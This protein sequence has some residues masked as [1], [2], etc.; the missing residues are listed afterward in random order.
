MLRLPDEVQLTCCSCI[1]QYHS[2]GH[3]CPALQ[4]R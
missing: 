4:S 3:L 1:K 2:E